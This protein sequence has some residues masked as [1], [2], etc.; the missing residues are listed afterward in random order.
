[1]LKFFKKKPKSIYECRKKELIRRIEEVIKRANS[2]PPD[3]LFG[4]KMADFKKWLLEPFAYEEY[5]EYEEEK[6]CL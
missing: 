2:E 1:M 4:K 6:E 3:W 5:D